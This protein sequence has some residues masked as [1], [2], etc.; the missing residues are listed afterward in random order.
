MSE[1]EGKL[2][3]VTGSTKGIGKAIAEAFV[4]QKARVVVHGRDPVEARCVANDAFFVGPLVQNEF[5]WIPGRGKQGSEA[6]C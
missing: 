2:T 5:S 4:D 3:L 1:I 6:E